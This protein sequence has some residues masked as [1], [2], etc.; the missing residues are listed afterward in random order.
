[1]EMAA[2]DKYVTK[3][4]I[5]LK[6]MKPDSSTK[7][8]TPSTVAT[9]ARIKEEMERLKETVQAHQTRNVYLSAELTRIEEEAQ[10]KL[11]S[12]QQT[13]A[14]LETELEALNKQYQELR[15]Q[16]LMLKGADGTYLQELESVKKAFVYHFFI[17]CLHF[18]LFSLY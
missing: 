14:R 17:S 5:Q 11:N 9:P 3:L 2:K 18:N 4:T 13:I 1:M 15:T 7:Q 12:K 16:N 6:Q 8:R 10:A